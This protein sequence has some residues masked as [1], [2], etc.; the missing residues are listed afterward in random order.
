MD[1]K[2]NP[3]EK[4]V[5]QIIIV[6]VALIVFIGYN[7]FKDY[8]TKK[9]EYIESTKTKI[10]TD[11]SRYYTVLNCAQ[12]YI[13]YVYNNDTEK[14]LTVMDEQYKKDYGVT[15]INIS[16]FT[17]KLESNYMYDYVGNGMHYKIISENVSEYYIDGQIKKS[18]M[19]GDGEYLDYDVTVTLYEDKFIFSVKPGAEY[20][21]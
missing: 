19:D 7:I 1:K 10:V 2:L 8:N 16:N 21:D 6:L 15:A 18:I 12:K 11:A 9:S 17:P 20:E 13:N 5:F 4:D 3:K 14:I